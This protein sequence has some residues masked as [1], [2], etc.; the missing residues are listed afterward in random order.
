M[1]GDLYNLLLFEPLL[2]AL[3]FIYNYIPNL[4]V[5]III[6]TIIIKFVLYIPS[7]SSIQAQKRLQD[8]QPQMKAIQEKYKNDKEKLGQELM[9]FYKENKVNPFSSCLPLLLQLPILI[10]LYR[11]FLAV[12]QTDPTTNILLADQLQ[13]LYEPMRNIFE[14][15]AIDPNFLGF[16]DLSQKGNWVLALLAGAAQFWQSKMLASKRPPKVPGAKDENMM[17]G[18]NKQMT[19]FMPL[20]TVFFAY[21]FPAGLALYWLVSTLFSAVQQ[22]YLFRKNKKPEMEVISN[23]SKK[24]GNN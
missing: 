24:T 7:R 13:H 6:L 16:F 4:G 8:T 10:A 12:A 11:V 14:T 23:E 20:I 2:N 15:K 17:A 19:Y 3:V 18:M 21:Q 9:K 5:A 1:I 22:L